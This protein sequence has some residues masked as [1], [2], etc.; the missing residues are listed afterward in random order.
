VISLLFYYIVLP[1]IA[2]YYVIKL[3][4]K[5]GGSTVPPEVSALYAVD[6]VQ[7]KWYRAARRDQNGRVTKLGDYETQLEAVDRAYLG[8]EEAQKA[9]E[10]ASFLVLNDKGD[11]YQQVDS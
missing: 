3:I 5:H 4:K 10:K 9:G 7:K 2:A 8:K 6:P 11:V 1:M